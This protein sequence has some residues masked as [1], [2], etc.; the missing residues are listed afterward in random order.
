MPPVDDAEREGLALPDLAK[1]ILDRQIRPR[2]SE[3][4]RLAEAVLEAQ[5]GDASPKPK[6]AKK[7]K[8]ADKGKKSGKKSGK[9]AK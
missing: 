5:S 4:R 3:I 8:S 2:V 9:K 1:A 7:A 6:K